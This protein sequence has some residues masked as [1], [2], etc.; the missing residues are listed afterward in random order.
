LRNGI[1]YLP[2]LGAARAA[3][4][5]KSREDFASRIRGLNL[6]LK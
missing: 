4:F 3:R 5:Q 2:L 6:Q 1:E